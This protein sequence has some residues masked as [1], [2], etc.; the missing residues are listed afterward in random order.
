[1]Y[2]FGSQFDNTYILQPEQSVKRG[3]KTKKPAGAPTTTVK[4][5]NYPQEQ[6]TLAEKQGMPIRRVGEEQGMLFHPEHYTRTRR[7]PTISNF[8]QE[9]KKRFS[10]IHFDDIE[11]DN[12][13]REL[14]NSTMNL[15]QIE[16]PRNLGKMDLVNFTETQ[17]NVLGRY[18]PSTGL[19]RGPQRNTLKL[20]MFSQPTS[21]SIIHELGHRMHHSIALANNEVPGAQIE[22]DNQYRGAKQFYSPISEGIAEG[23]AERYGSRYLTLPRTSYAPK[24]EPKYHFQSP[25][26]GSLIDYRL[27]PLRLGDL[28]WDERAGYG[29][30]HYAWQHNIDRALHSLVRL[31]VALNGEESIK[32]LPNLDRI[33][34]EHHYIHDTPIGPA[35][36]NKTSYNRAK[37]LAIGKLVYENESLR[38]VFDGD[39]QFKGLKKVTDDALEHYKIHLQNLAIANQTH[40]S[41]IKKYHKIF[42]PYRVY[43]PGKIGY[44]QAIS[45]NEINQQTLPDILENQPKRKIKKIIINK[46]HLSETERA[47][48]TSEAKRAPFTSSD[49]DNFLGSGG[50]MIWDNY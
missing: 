28:Q 5:F 39:E 19:D 29:V 47:P 6:Q 23:I 44:S 45:E 9:I 40:S 16:N 26:H 46:K 20:R 18:S 22:V 41:E 8:E 48:F 36:Y 43:K 11:K 13:A 42:D 17:H 3:R 4:T 25:K 50:R 33:N 10:F 12:F 34:W 7:D 30:N 27:N 21:H 35:K 14:S 2:Q 15:E 49:D 32:D 1:M 31:H 24:T 38:T 37:Y